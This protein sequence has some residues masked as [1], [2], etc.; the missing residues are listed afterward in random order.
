MSR[1]G[2]PALVPVAQTSEELQR[3]RVMER[4]EEGRRRILAGI[5]EPVVELPRA[6]N[7]GQA[8]EIVRN[9][10]PVGDLRSR[11]QLL[12][13]QEA[14]GREAVAQITEATKGAGLAF[15]AKTPAEV[16]EEFGSAAQRIWD[17]CAGNEEEVRS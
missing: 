2:R 3:F 15:V 7:H 16:V 6:P 12:A 5:L 8:R 10:P 1:R 13:S 4:H 11:A 9:T 17:A 14:L